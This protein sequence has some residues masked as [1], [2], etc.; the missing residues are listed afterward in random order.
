MIDFSAERAAPLFVWIELPQ[1]RRTRRKSENKR[2]L[3]GF[4]EFLSRLPLDDV[5]AYTHQTQQDA[6]TK[7]R[8][9]V[10]AH[11]CTHANIQNSHRS[12]EFVKL[13]DSNLP[14][15]VEHHSG[16]TLKLI[17]FI[18]FSVYFMDLFSVLWN[19]YNSLDQ[20]ILLTSFP[21]SMWG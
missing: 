8:V 14:A 9:F 16:V 1:A 12:E 4:R 18:K 21:T 10:D 6:R 7:T 11:T 15:Y 13:S 20:G 17:L 2:E 5:F 3:K 19:C